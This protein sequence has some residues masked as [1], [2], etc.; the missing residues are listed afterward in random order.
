M[1]RLIP[2]QKFLSKIHKKWLEEKMYKLQDGYR[3]IGHCRV[4]SSKH[5]VP[6]RWWSWSESDRI[7]VPFGKT[8]F[9]FEL[10]WEMFQAAHCTGR[11]DCSEFEQ[12]SSRMDVLILMSVF[13]LYQ[14][15]KV[16]FEHNSVRK[17]QILSAC[18]CWD[19][20]LSSHEVNQNLNFV[21]VIGYE[22]SYL[23]FVFCLS[24]IL[25]MTKNI[26]DNTDLDL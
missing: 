16:S 5:Y 11:K 24:Q 23:E 25:L 2:K 15:L 22:D 10:I 26:W 7:P 14:W 4:L 20:R 6:Q 13:R 12:V 21:G 18:C 1:K 3:Q 17:L 9:S 19:A 8:S